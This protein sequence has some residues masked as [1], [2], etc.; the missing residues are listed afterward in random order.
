MPEPRVVQVMRE[1]KILLLARERAQMEEMARR[2]REVEDALE[3]QI[4]DLAREF[5][6]MRE[7]G[8]P[9]TQAQLY[10]LQRYRTLLG[11][12][13]REMRRYTQETTRLIADRQREWGRL[14]IRH[15]AAAIKTSYPTDVGAFFD[16]IPVEAVEAM[17]G[18]AGDGSPLRS[19]LEQSYPSV[20]D[21][22]TDALIRSTALGRN[23]RVTAREMRRRMA[24]G[25]SDALRVARTEQ[26]R[27]YRHAGRQQYIASGVV[28]GYYRLSA[29][30][31]RVCAACLAA[32]GEFY[33]LDQVLRDHPHGRCGQVP[34]VRGVPA[35][36][37][38]QGLSWFRQ[39][40]EE[41]Q[42]SILRPGRY[43][44]WRDGQFDFADLVSVRR[45]STWGDSVHPTPLSQLV[46]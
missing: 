24:V 45:D 4:S 10:R 29:H 35:P 26:I 9:I 32:E 37:W 5:A 19:L 20:A 28:E 17:V 33:R 13:Q 42:R 21:A 12:L 2:W 14:G 39:Q 15:A 43:A 36:R 40:S 23:P 44:A 22:M 41:V 27:V 3:A 11:Q 25:L 16:R 7:A 46:S 18:L 31:S 1:F 38:T 8:E 30:D 34:K 6:E